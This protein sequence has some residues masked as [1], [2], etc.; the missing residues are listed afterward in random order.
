VTGQMRLS[1]EAHHLKLGKAQSVASSRRQPPSYVATSSLFHKRL[2]V[3]ALMDGLELS[4]AHPPLLNR[5]GDLLAG[6]GWVVGHVQLV[7]Y[8]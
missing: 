6:D 4:R 7:C 2:G 8:Q 5:Y 3:E 1:P